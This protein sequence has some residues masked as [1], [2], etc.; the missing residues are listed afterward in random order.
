MITAPNDRLENLGGVA[1]LEVPLIF[2][3]YSLRREKDKNL[4]SPK[5]CALD[6]SDCPYDCRCNRHCGDDCS[7]DM[8]F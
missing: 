8:D 2:H 5:M 4:K 7:C 3:S 1:I 6:S